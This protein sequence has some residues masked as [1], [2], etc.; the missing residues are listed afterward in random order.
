[1]VRLLIALLCACSLLGGCA[2]LPRVSGGFSGDVVPF[3]STDRRIA[4]I[5]AIPGGR[6]VIAFEPDEAGSPLLVELLPGGATSPVP[7]SEWNRNLATGGMSPIEHFTSVT[8]LE[9]DQAGFLWVLDDGRDPEGE[10][11]PGGAK[12]VRIDTRSYRA[13]QVIFLPDGLLSPDSHLVDLQVDL[14]SGLLY[15]A[16]EGTPAILVLDISSGEGWI[17]LHR[18]PSLTAERSM[19]AAGGEVIR[20][21]DGSMQ[22]G[23]VSSLLLTPD[24]GHLLYQ[25]LSGTTLYRIGTHLLRKGVGQSDVEQGVEIVARTVIASTIQRDPN[26]G[27]L[28]A[29]IQGGGIVRLT[30]ERYLEPV[31]HDPLL[32]YPIAVSVPSSGEMIVA[33][34]RTGCV[35]GQG[36]CDR[37]VR[38]TFPG[39][40]P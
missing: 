9:V 29:E 14:P 31:V 10:I 37:L 1:M 20:N 26:G 23:N 36:G 4:D 38:I 6:I 25:A 3:Y 32:N 24:G 17:P 30:P 5:A 35:P 34:R 15:I 27:L 12:V 33:T 21:P 13:H 11:A 22:G 28:L 16:D 2:R 19:I 7:D 8:A 39:G 40:R 18:H